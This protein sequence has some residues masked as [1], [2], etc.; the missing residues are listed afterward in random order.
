MSFITALLIHDISIYL[1]YLPGIT[2]NT[3][4]V[5]VPL[6]CVYS[7]EQ[8]VKEQGYGKSFLRDP[9]GATRRVIKI[10]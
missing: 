7:L 10:H 1:N 9:A 8:T 6:F 4:F 3:G 5:I 2:G